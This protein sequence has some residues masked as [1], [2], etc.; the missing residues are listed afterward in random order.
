MLLADRNNWPDFVDLSVL[1]LIG[2]A[3]ISVV[4]AGYAWMFIDFRRYLRSLRRTLI[5][6]ANYLPHIPAWARQETP[7]CLVAM[8]LR[9]P[10][11]E[12]DVLRSYRKKV[13]RLHPDRGGDQR[14][15]L[16]LQA[17]FEQA[18]AYVREQVRGGV[19]S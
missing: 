4:I 10:C 5:V 1:A 12:A 18:L 17:D 19:A 13:K 7:R 14:R 16:V 8:G 15:F 6:V 2:G 9:M 11:T 3:V